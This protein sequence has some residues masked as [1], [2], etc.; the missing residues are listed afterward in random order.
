LRCCNP[1]PWCIRV[2]GWFHRRHKQA[3]KRVGYVPWFSWRN[4]LIVCVVLGRRGGVESH[5]CRHDIRVCT[6]SWQ[7]H[8]VGVCRPG[9]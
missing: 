8:I 9:D 6:S 4:S 2:W 7:V 3:T 1:H 5:V